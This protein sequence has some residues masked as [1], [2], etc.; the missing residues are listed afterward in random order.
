[1]VEMVRGFGRD[2]SFDLNVLVNPAHCFLPLQRAEYTSP[3]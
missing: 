3:I 1:M 2:P